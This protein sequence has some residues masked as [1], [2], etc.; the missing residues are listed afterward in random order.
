MN[1]EHSEPNWE[2]MLIEA[3]TVPGKILEAYT[4]FHNYSL[5][6][7]MLAAGQC[8]AREI[9]LGPI[10]TYPGWVALGR[11]VK[12]GSKAIALVMPI[13]CKRKDSADDETEPG[14]YTRFV[15]K[16]N[17]FVLAQ[18]DGEAMPEAKPIPEWDANRALD[19]LNIAKVPFDHIDG[20]SQGYAKANSIAINPIA[21]LPHKTMFHEL[22]HVILGHTAESV[23]A[24]GDR[25]PRSLKEAEAEAVALLCCESLGLDGA[26]YARGY[27]QHWLN[28]S[29]I[30]ATSARKIFSAASK[31]L[32][33]GKP[34][35]EKIAA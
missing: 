16:N 9:P 5:G 25:T 17:W 29:T 18:T 34:K 27:I 15:L 8:A 21:A 28:G 35:S 20:N 4:I 23:M 1:T 11:Q 3:V 33:A 10:N 19:A 13:T 32:Q 12:K 2:A 14:C 30:P 31:I 6:N 22:G 7:A 24:D 26:E